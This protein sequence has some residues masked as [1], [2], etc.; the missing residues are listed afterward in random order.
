M[1]R[2]EKR[3]VY[4]IRSDADPSRHYTGITSNLSDRLK[5]HNYRVDI[6]SGIDRGR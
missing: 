1:D 4:I 6:P 3:I 2:L 5:W